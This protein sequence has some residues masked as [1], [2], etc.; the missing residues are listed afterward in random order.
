MKRLDKRCLSKISAL[1]VY[2]FSVDLIP[3]KPTSEAVKCEKVP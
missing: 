1:M 3:R 2:E